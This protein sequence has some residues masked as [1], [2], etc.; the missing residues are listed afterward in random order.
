M[1]K[2]SLNMILIT[3]LNLIFHFI[4]KMKLMVCLKVY[5]LFFQDRLIVYNQKC[6]FKLV[7]INY[8]NSIYSRKHSVFYK[9]YLFEFLNK[10]ELSLSTSFKLII[11]YFL[12]H[13]YINH[14][15]FEWKKIHSPNLFVKQIKSFLKVSNC[16]LLPWIY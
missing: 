14:D 11:I 13:I 4:L 9:K 3:Q 1:L 5:N 15:L 12:S 7:I 6:I 8:I 10:M 16:S 2:N